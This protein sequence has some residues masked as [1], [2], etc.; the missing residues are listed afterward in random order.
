MRDVKRVLEM[1]S[2]NHSQRDIARATKISRDTV[3]KIFN[4]AD[5]KKICWSSIQDLSE[6]DV[7]KLLFEEE[8][9]I[10]LSIKQPDFDY[11]HKELLKPG[12]T[13]KLLWEEYADACRSINVPFYQYSYFCERYRDHVKKHN[14]TMHI[15]HK[16]GDKMMVDWNGTCMYIYDRYTGER[17]TAYLFEATL[18]F[19]MYSYVRACPSMKIG[20]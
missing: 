12:T 15:N 9:K 20:D 2:Q 18:P 13:I 7:Q 4:A 14:L 3:R 17:I 6:Y 11:V 10:N 1:R 8:V 16:P 5:S 19:S